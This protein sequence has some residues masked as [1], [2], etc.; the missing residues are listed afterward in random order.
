MARRRA[1]RRRALEILYQ[2]DATHRTPVQVLE[3]RRALGERVS[4]F[5][6]E[7][8]TGASERLGEIDRQIGEHAIDWTV[9]RMAAV[10]R[11]ILRLAVYELLYRKDVP[12]AVAIDEAVRAA[13][14]LSTRESGG[15]VNGILGRIAISLGGSPAR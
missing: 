12:V 7:L 11:A 9:D 14:R 6:E 4:A 5:T 8:V 3:E 1:A 2:A 15:F 10:D 13:K